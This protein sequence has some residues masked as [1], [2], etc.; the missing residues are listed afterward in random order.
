MTWS[1]LRFNRLTLAAVLSNFVEGLGWEQ[2]TG[3]EPTSSRGGMTASHMKM[4]AVDVIDNSDIL[5]LL[6]GTANRFC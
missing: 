4:P 5:D 6:G 3:Q 2:E 1:R